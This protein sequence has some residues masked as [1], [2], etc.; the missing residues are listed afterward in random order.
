MDP[1]LLPDEV[2]KVVTSD[3]TSNIENL[4]PDLGLL[5]LHYICLNTWD[6]VTGCQIRVCNQKIIY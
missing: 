2:S 4:D 6:R 3:S 1:Y 5:Y